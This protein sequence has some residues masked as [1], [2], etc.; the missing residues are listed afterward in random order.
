MIDEEAKKRL[1]Q[2]IDDA[3][4]MTMLMLISFQTDPKGGGTI[5]SHICPT[6]TPAL[7]KYGLLDMC[8]FWLDSSAKEAA[9][10]TAVVGIFGNA[11]H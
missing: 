3:D 9:K 4:E 1:H 7:I 5:C 11:P 8:R 2:A 6:G 10:P